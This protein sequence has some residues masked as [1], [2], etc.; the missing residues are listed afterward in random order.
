MNRS[1]GKAAAASRESHLTLRRVER[2][3]YLIERL[4]AT[5]EPL[6]IGRLALDLG[7]SERTIARDLERL[8]HSG[9]PITLTPGR[10]GG[11]QLDH[12]PAPVPI[13]LDFPEIAALL[14]SLAALGPTASDSASSAMIKLTAALRPPT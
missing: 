5:P 9:V 10:G 11:A 2:Q 13:D 1:V 8:R 14:A 3:Q 6:T 12:G 4:H 7:V